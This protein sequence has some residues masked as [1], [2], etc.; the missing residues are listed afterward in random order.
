[1]RKQG[2]RLYTGGAKD[3]RREKIGKRRMK[4]SGE[5]EGMNQKMEE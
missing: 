2:R 3:G 4:E 1:M 5:D